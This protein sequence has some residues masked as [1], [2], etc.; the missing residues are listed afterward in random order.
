MGF[1]KPFPMQGAW[2]GARKSCGPSPKAARRLMPKRALL[3]PHPSLPRLSK[4]G[5]VRG[6]GFVDFRGLAILGAAQGLSELAGCQKKHEHVAD[7]HS[8]SLS[9]SSSGGM[10][11]F[12]CRRVP[13]S[14]SGLKI[15]EKLKYFGNGSTW[16]IESSPNHTFSVPSLSSLSPG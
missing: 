15:G 13:W 8:L 14:L 7:C 5:G 2:K 11:G 16:N 1:Q 6:G 9:L 3:D 12:R 10:F 4:L